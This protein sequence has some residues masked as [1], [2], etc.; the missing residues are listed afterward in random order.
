[1]GPNTGPN[2]GDT[3]RD[4]NFDN[5]PHSTDASI[6]AMIPRG[7]IILILLCLLCLMSLVILL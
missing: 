3:K 1:M 2:L 4:H 6:V 7:T 5:P